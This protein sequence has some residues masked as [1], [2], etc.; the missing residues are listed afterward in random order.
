MFEDILR[1]INLIF[2][3]H[4]GVIKNDVS[5]SAHF[6]VSKLRGWR[7]VEN[8]RTLALLFSASQPTP[9]SPTPPSVPLVF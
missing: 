4:P 1:N 5:F 9:T 6:V 3:A 2:Q 8:I 7:S